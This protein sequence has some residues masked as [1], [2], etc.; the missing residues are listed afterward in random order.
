MGNLLANVS[1]PD[2]SSFN[3]GANLTFSAVAPTL[4]CP[5]NF[6]VFC[7]AACLPVCGG[8]SPYSNTINT[9]YAVWTI[10]MFVICV[11]GGIIDFVAYYLNRKTM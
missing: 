2:C 7:D 11:T 5:D 6:D 3:D 1:I 8:V 4:T 10:A 9:F